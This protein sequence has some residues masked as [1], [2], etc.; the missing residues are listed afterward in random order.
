M[1]QR[2]WY[3][4][5]RITVAFA[6]TTSLLTLTISALAA[7]KFW[8]TLQAE[9]DTLAREELEETRAFFA[10]SART[11][12][13]F[14]AMAGEMAGQHLPNR[15]AW[16]I[17]ETTSRDPWGDFGAA[18]LLRQTT[19]PLQARP[20]PQSLRSSRRW[21]TSELT[22][23]L[24]VGILLDASPSIERFQR[25]VLTALGFVLASALLATL[26]GV[27]LG[28]R[29]SLL[30]RRVASSAH[31]EKSEPG[32]DDGDAPQEIR[33]VTTALR[34]ALVR[35]RKEEANARLVTSGL[36]H[37]LRSP[38]QNLIGET[39]VALLRERDPTEYRRVLESHLEELGQLGRVVDNLITLCA[40]GELR[41]GSE[42]FDLGE[43]AR[44]RL[45]REF[46]LGHRRDV[47]VELH[48]SG[49][50]DCEGDREALLL[51]LRNLVTNAIEWSPKGATV[52]VRLHGDERSVEMCVHDAGPG[53]PPAE[54]VGI[55][56][57]FH[58]NRVAPGRR[59]GFGLGLALTR[60]AVEAHEGR[61]EVGESPLGGACF[62]ILLP[63]PGPERERA[64]EEER[65]RATPETAGR[66]RQ[67]WPRGRDMPAAHGASRRPRPFGRG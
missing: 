63:K 43:E 1:A 21:I 58:R 27:M 33:A 29:V 4:A 5:R 11:H 65:G 36:A 47:R 19:L 39:Q 32:T 64:A 57:P 52:E 54:R 22:P 35:I 51:A 20:G 10:G 31:V 30:L 53:V 55:L 60:S 14:A 38:L 44:L 67:G 45:A 7:W 62:R 12:E 48:A 9:I 28:R 50:L 6:V 23:E 56:E 66:T 37:E 59:G 26:A 13:E 25:F 18:D 2:P 16:R 61:I 40:A 46:E 3:L 41:R 34:E 15:L 8:T 49:S 24:S 17:W 42:R